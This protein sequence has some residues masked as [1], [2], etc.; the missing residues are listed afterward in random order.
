[1]SKSQEQIPVEKTSQKT[2]IDNADFIVE[3]LTEFDEFHFSTI[4]EEGSWKREILRKFARKNIIV[5]LRTEKYD[6]GNGNHAYRKIWQL[7][8]D[9]LRMAEDVV[10]N[11]NPILPCGHS[12]FRNL[13]DGPFE[14][15][16]RGCSR[17]FERAD[18]EFVEV[19]E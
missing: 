10:E 14:C 2:V 12:G 9:A 18:G 8:A 15:H 4:A 3:E 13:R 7:K 5:S 6:I 17:Q 16:Y 11:R 1:M 19:I